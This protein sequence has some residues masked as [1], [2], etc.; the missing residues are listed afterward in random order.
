MKSTPSHSQNL[1]F[2]PEEQSE[3]VAFDFGFS[4]RGFVQLLSTGLFVAA[5]VAPA[6]AQRARG[7]GG[8]GFFGASIRNLAARI[9]IG[10]DGMI[11]VLA[12]KVEMGQGARAEL[13][14]AAAEELRVS[15]S[16]IQM[17]LSDTA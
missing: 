2:D 9:H 5:N 10:K 3:K 17:V 14:L 8:G 15:A 12:G 7:G 6:I 11:T 13:T 4:R 1:P 16:Q